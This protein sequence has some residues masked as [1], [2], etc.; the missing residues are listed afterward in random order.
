M[1]KFM[2]LAFS[3]LTISAS[4]FSQGSP[5]A[6]ATGQVNGATITISY[7]SPSVKGRPIWNSLV[8]YGKVWR[9]GANKATI[10]ETDKDI[11]IEGKTLPAG[12]YSLYILPEENEWT[13][14]FNSAT[15]QWGITRQGET[16]QDPTKDVLRVKVKPKKSAAMQEGLKYDVNSKGFSL[17]WENL[18]VPV[19]IK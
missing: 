10:F 5:A 11:S 13:M 18:V 3:A 4:V 12:K 2:L 15:G 1:K 14:I 6:T 16:T 7:G 19:S 9:A 8:P 17:A